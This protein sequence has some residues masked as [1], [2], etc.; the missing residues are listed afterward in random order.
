MSGWVWVGV[1]GAGSDDNGG[2]VEES[3]CGGTGL[4][5]TFPLTPPPRAFPLT[6]PP[7]PRALQVRPIEFSD[8]QT[9]AAAIRPSVTR[10]QL[11][12]FEE[13]TAKFGTPT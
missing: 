6:L 12:V 7:R 1:K 4:S 2:V 5:C 11:R 8:F 13:W 3:T 10:E 9:A